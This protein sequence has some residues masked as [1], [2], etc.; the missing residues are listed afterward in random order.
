MSE[1]LTANFQCLALQ[2]AYLKCYPG[3]FFVA[4]KIC[5]HLSAS[6]SP[7]QSAHPVPAWFAPAWAAGWS[8]V[9]FILCVASLVFPACQ[10]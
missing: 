1:G 6:L 2:L 9:G 8:R 10:R 7:T 3:G 5:G 4:D